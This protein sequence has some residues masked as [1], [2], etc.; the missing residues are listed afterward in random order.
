MVYFFQEK[1]GSM[2]DKTK[3][4][5]KLILRLG[6]AMGLEE[7]MLLVAQNAAEVAVSDLA[8]TMVIEFTSLAG[9]MG[10]HYALREGYSQEIADAIFE[11]V[12]PRF[13]GDDLPKTDAGILLSVADRL[14]SL[15]GLF[16]VG[17]QPSATSDPFGLRRLSHGLVQVLVENK[18]NVDLNMAI[19]IAADVQPLHISPSVINDV[20][21]FV[22]RRLEQL[23]VD[24]GVSVEIVRSILSERANTPFLA[25]LSAVQMKNLSESDTFK[26]VVEAYSRPTKIIRGKSID[27]ALEVDGALFQLEEE[28][29]LWNAF[30]SVQSRINPS[31]GIDV[32]I[33]ASVQLI[34]P[35][36]DFFNNVFVMAEDENLRKNRLALLGRIASLPRGI[37]DLSLLPGF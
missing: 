7:N 27:H 24:Q 1:L 6:A 3:R 22:T 37:A 26:K 23:L 11:R 17:C 25:S 14:D 30:Q 36:E 8:T 35:L 29:A 10:R 2:L 4:V 5:E 21:L 33:E 12:L 32:F 9:I 19:Q 34:Q 15:V 13:A 16:A 28:K 18:K 20:H 31:V